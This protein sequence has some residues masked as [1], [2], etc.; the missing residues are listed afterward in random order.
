MKQYPYVEVIKGST[1]Y[2]IEEGTDPECCDTCQK[3]ADYQ[4]FSA[5]DVLYLS[6]AS[7]VLKYDLPCEDEAEVIEEIPARDF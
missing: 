6:C 4:T 5:D 2:R 1:F 7:C 3:A